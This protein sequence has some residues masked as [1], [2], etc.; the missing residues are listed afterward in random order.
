MRDREEKKKGGPGADKIQVRPRGAL[1]NVPPSC[2][3]QDTA[4][5]K[6]PLP[7]FVFSLVSHLSYIDPH[8]CM[9]QDTTHSEY[10]FPYFIF[11]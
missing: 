10:L 9:K 1:T 2:A 6:Y 8:S 4:Y 11:F 5:S 7:Y 3:E